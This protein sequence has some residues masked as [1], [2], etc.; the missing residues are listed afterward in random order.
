MVAFKHVTGY[1]EFLCWSLTHTHTLLPPWGPKL[2]QG[3]TWAVSWASWSKQVGTWILAPSWPIFF[4]VL[5]QLFRYSLLLSKNVLRVWDYVKQDKTSILD[6][7]RSCFEFPTINSNPNFTTACIDWPC[8]QPGGRTEN[9]ANS[10]FDDGKKFLDRYVQ[11]TAM[12]VRLGIKKNILKDSDNVFIHML[13]V[14]MVGNFLY[15]PQET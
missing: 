15:I 13:G 4:E 10:I 2:S 1:H 3:S 7:S 8:F 11:L 6:W 9:E 5:T 12:S 14:L